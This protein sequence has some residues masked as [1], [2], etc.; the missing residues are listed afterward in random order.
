MS[1]AYKCDNCGDFDEG[2]AMVTADFR[3]WLNREGEEQK[4]DA[5]AQEYCSVHCFEEAKKNDFV[6]R[7]LT[8]IDI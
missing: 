8:G 1:D 6:E 4:Q 3:V 7:L 5:Q 2:K